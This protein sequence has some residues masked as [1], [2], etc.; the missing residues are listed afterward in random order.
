MELKSFKMYLLEYRNL[1]IFQE[2]VVNKVLDAVV[3]A[4]EPVWASVE[5]HFEARGGHATRISAE[6]RR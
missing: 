1:P 4:A 2:N 5:G 6:Y 3:N